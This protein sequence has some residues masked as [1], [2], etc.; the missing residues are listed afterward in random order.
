MFDTWHR[1]NWAK[2]QNIFVLSIPKQD[3]GY[4]FDMSNSVLAGNLVL[5]RVLLLCLATFYASAALFG[6]MVV[7]ARM[8]IVKTFF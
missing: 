6:H 2:F 3:T 1:I 4:I 5:V 8:I 7:G